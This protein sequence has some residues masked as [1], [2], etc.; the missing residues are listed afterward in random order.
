MNIKKFAALTNLT[1]IAAPLVVQLGA[2]AAPVGFAT[3]KD[4]K[5]AVYLGGT[6]KH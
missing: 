1:M 6:P 3:H 5:G 2:V 4:L